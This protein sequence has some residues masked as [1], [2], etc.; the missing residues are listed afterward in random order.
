MKKVCALMAVYNEAD[1]ILESVSK[2]LQHGVDVHLIDNA[3]T[4]GTVERVQHLVG[5]G[6]I[7]IERL[8]F[9]EDGREVYNWTALLKAKEALARRLG[10]DWYLHVDAD[11]IR[12]PPWPGLSLREGIDRVDAA[13]FN[14]INFKLFNFR[15][16]AGLVPGPEYESTM[17]DFSCG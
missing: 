11:E 10:Y 3:S 9:F 7:D 5:R 2:L 8:Q 4:D 14:L 17:L 16:T 6:L 12:L 15:L 13:G 1:I